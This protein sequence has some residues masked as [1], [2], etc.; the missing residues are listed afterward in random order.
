M[1]TQIRGAPLPVR[2]GYKKEKAREP[3]EEEKRF[4]AWQTL[5]QARDRKRMFGLK[6]KRAAEK[7]EQ[8]K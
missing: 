4:K 2:Q 6:Q 7:A 1:A 5:K 8:E 3:T